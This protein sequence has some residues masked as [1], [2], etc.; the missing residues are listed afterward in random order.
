ME[1]TLPATNGWRPFQSVDVF[2]GSERSLGEVELA[3]AAHEVRE[4]SRAKNLGNVTRCPR[5]TTLLRFLFL[6]RTTIV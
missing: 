3:P 2:D 5:R 1:A 4:R 6:E